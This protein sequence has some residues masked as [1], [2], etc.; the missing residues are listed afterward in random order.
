MLH[1]AKPLG[2]LEAHAGRGLR[3]AGAV[4]VRHAEHLFGA[5][6]RQPPRFEG[7]EEGLVLLN[8]RG[9]RGRRG[10]LRQAA[11]RLLR[12]RLRG[13]AGGRSAVGAGPADASAGHVPGAQRARQPVQAL[14]EAVPTTG[15]A[16]LGMYRRTA[17]Q[18][19]DPQCTHHLASRQRGWKVL[20]VDK[21]QHRGHEGIVIGCSGHGELEELRGNVK[22]VAVIGIDNEYQ[23]VCSWHVVSD[24][25][26]GLV[27]EPEV[28]E[29]Q[30][31][32]TQVQ[33]LNIEA[34]GW[35]GS[36]RGSKLQL[37]KD[38]C[39][40]SSVKSKHDNSLLKLANTYQ[41][42]PTRSGCLPHAASNLTYKW[43]NMAND[44]RNKQKPE[45]T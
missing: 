42:T 17:R 34:N 27:S 14:V 26:A 16:T 13:S 23:S 8:A 43:L 19:G 35:Y 21:D 44:E 29:C 15:A 18:T 4:Q 2:R 25:G 11:I 41:T 28:P 20:L 9:R 1:V 33:G 40:A 37:V 45:T 24:Q 3:E 39:L 22:T 6:A 5:E 10:H 30:G 36:D 38:G 7:R 12:G 32:A 31:A